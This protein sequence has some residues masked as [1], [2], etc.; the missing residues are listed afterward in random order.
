MI[1]L[2]INTNLGLLI[3]RLGVGGLMLIHGLSKIAGGIGA[4][5]YLV[6]S[7]GLPSFIAYGVYVGEV[8][9]PVMILIGL[10]TRIAAAI[11]A[12]NCLAAVFMYHPDGFL[13]LNA[14]GGWS[15]ELIVLFLMGA[16]A[17]FFTGA[18]RYALSRRSIWD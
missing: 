8:I 13:A 6:E 9:A 10:R 3:M 11:M 12:V 18:G 15:L 16:V 4:V 17:L 5:K 14:T 1:P 2:N 7:A